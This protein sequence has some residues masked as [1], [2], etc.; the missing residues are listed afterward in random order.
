MVI[1]RK[2]R[3]EDKNEVEYGYKKSITIHEPWVYP[4]KNYDE[5]LK[6]E[7]RYF[8]CL[9]E[10]GS[11]VGTFNISGVVRGHFQS[12]YLGYEVFSPYNG[13]GYMTAGL[14]LLLTEA[15]SALNLHRLEANIQPE[16]TNSIRL[17]SNAGFVKEG[18]SKNYLNIGGLGWKDHE[19]WAVVNN[20]WSSK[21]S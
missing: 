16:N 9:K 19:R 5:Y 18:F 3:P 15:F 10:T 4:P 13:K 2:P 8:L 14:G 7:G 17:V 6:D 1:L 21:H 12:G 11:I 20:D